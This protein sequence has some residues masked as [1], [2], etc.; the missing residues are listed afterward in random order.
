MIFKRIFQIC[1]SLLLFVSAS[2][3]AALETWRLTSTIVDV[4]PSRASG[5]APDFLSLGA[6]VTVDY[7]IDT[8][9]VLL[10]NNYD[11]AV[12]SV[13]FNGETSGGASF[14][15]YLGFVNGP[16]RLNVSL[17]GRSND[18]VSFISLEDFAGPAEPTVSDELN[19]MASH[20]PF[21]AI[22]L[23]FEFNN[24]AYS[25]FADVISLAAVP[26][27]STLAMIL[28]GLGICGFSA[29]PKKSVR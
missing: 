13:S 4:Y 10:A 6:T 12:K 19:K 8:S 7:L 5:V 22:A 9:A 17:S 27:P 14:G 29:R 26:E 16:S 20:I 3:Q 18:T 24:G 1:V 15:G 11:D 21:A 2:S 23:T 28:S 25:A